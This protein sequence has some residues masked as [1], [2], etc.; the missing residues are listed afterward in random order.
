MNTSVRNIAGSTKSEVKSVYES[1]V[2]LVQL[3]PLACLIIGPL[4]GLAYIS[5]TI[6]EWLWPLESAQRALLP[7]AA[8]PTLLQGRLG[9]FV[10]FYSLFVWIFY[11][12][13]SPQGA[14]QSADAWQ[15]KRLSS[16]TVWKH[17][18]LWSFVFGPLGYL[19][20]LYTGM[21]WLQWGL[22]AVGLSWAFYVEVWK[23]FAWQVKMNRELFECVSFGRL[24]D[25][26]VR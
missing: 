19:C 18:I 8:F 25:H 9:A 20:G 24:A 21:S 26:N 13:P 11:I 3:I 4:I 22:L 16:H 12:L 17:V 7:S 10:V 5:W 23:T 15:G 6:Y 1:V 14:K 2:L